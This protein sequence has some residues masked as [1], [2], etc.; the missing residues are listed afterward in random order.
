MNHG[1]S[2]AI[3]LGVRFS[4]AL[5][6][7]GVADFERDRARSWAIRMELPMLLIALW[8][9]F[10]WYLSATGKLP[11][12]EG[13]LLDQLIWVLFALEQLILIAL[14]KDKRFY[15]RTNWL[16]IGVVLVGLPLVFLNA[17]EWLL[18]LRLLRGGLVGIAVLRGG[19]RYFRELGQHVFFAL[20]I[21]TG[22]VL[23]L[24]GAIM[25]T[26]EPETF[27]SFHTAA[28]WTLVTISTV[29]Y[30][31]IVPQTQFGRQLAMGLILIGVVW[32]SLI[33]AMIAAF[34]VGLRMELSNQEEKQFEKVLL[35]RLDRIEQQLARLE[36]QQP[37][38]QQSS[39]SRQRL[40]RHRR[41][42]SR[43]ETPPDD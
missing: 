9:P 33:S 22:F 4:R 12:E 43:E 29:G 10:H 39:V 7:A 41:D 15:L 13:L 3:R 21:M 24:G 8:I 6:V 18:G 16:L 19:R 20:M 36:Q 17:A 1:V 42:A 26:I 25:P 34:L 30:G 14:V 11:P 23:M 38:N 28:W 37:S 32:M 5:G 40:A 31:D 35:E 27:P 2:R